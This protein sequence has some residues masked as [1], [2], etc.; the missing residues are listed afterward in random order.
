MENNR[1][2]EEIKIKSTG[3]ILTVIKFDDSINKWILEDSNKKQYEII[4][5]PKLPSYKSHIKVGEK[6]KQPFVCYQF[7]QG[8]YILCSQG[9]F[10][11]R[12]YG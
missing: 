7:K 12:I 6:F 1:I 11:R 5:L 8:N 10:E 2:G 9:C 3:E 4:T